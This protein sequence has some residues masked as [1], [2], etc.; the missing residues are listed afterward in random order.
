M[1]KNASDLHGL[2]QEPVERLAAG[3]LKQEHGP[4]LFA[5]QRQR[6]RRRG[7]VQLIF[8]CVFVD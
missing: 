4:P 5:H 3:V 6:P 7:T 1:R 2:P 8:Q